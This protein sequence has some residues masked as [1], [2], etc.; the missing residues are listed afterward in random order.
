MKKV[1]KFLNFPVGK[2]SHLSTINNKFVIE[3][4]TKHKII[5]KGFKFYII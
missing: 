3:L 5:K 2:S 4:P 1:H